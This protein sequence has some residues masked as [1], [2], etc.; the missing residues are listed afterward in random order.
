MRSRLRGRGTKLP[1]NY[2]TPSS[3]P[4]EQEPV[5]DGQK[6]DHLIFHVHKHELV[7]IQYSRCQRHLEGD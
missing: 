6:Q 4:E 7:L 5:R 2:K 3:G 1:R